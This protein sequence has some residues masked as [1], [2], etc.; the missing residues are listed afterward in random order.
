M[1]RGEVCKPGEHASLSMYRA[2]GLQDHN[3]CPD[4]QW[5][6]AHTLLQC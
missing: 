4:T 5:C 6:T 2:F 1:R 3:I